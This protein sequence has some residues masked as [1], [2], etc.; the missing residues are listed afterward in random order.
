M[1]NIG[2]EQREVIFVPVPEPAEAPVKEPSPGT[3]PVPDREP[4]PA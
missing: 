2:E 3:E 4:V 1:G